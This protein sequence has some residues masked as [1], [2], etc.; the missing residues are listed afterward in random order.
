MSEMEITPQTHCIICE[1]SSEMVL[2]P[3]CEPKPAKRWRKSRPALAKMADTDLLREF[4][5]FSSWAGDDFSLTTPDHWDWKRHT[6]VE[7]EILRRMASI[8]LWNCLMPY[9]LEAII[10]HVLAQGRPGTHQGVLLGE[11]ERLRAEVV[12]LEGRQCAACGAIGSIWRYTGEE[13]SDV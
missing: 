4:G 11:V 12:R 13:T 1:T 3:S 9:D 7:T 2:C 10:S 5:S 8:A 6:K